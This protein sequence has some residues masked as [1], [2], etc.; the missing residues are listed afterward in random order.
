[1]RI[2]RWDPDK[3]LGVL[4]GWLRAR[5][6]AL[7]AG[8]AKLYPST[9]FLVGRCAVGFV[10]ATNA[11]HVGY[12]DGIVTDPKATGRQRY[13]A[14]QDL[15]VELVGE[16]EHLGIKLLWATSDVKGLSRICARN[17]FVTYRTGF[18]CMYRTP[19]VS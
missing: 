11:P 1:M 14:L 10:Y 7:D 15:C 18:T 16:A 13:L 17:G 3:H 8:D 9:G 12:L 6:Q 5:G 2:E 4:G 19:G